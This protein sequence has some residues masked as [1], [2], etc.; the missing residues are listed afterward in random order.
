LSLN[1]NATLP[2]FSSDTPLGPLQPL[3]LASLSSPVPQPIAQVINF[4]YSTVFALLSGQ[5]SSLFFSPNV[6]SSGICLH[7][8]NG[9]NEG[10]VSTVGIINGSDYTLLSSIKLDPMDPTGSNIT[11]LS[12]DEVNE[13]FGLSPDIPFIDILSWTFYVL[14]CVTLYDF[15]Q[16]Y[17]FS[18]GPEPVPSTPS[19]LA[20]EPNIFHNATAFENYNSFLFD[21]ICPL[22]DIENN[23]II[24][25]LPLSD[26][27]R[28]QA[29]GSSLNETYT[30]SQRQLKTWLSLSISVL[31][32]DTAL[33]LGAYG[34]FIFATGYFQERRDKAKAGEMGHC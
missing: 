5:S 7:Y 4:Y 12:S 11:G 33:I 24:N 23:S 34:L 18:S 10:Q 19:K 16:L 17:E 3:N 2:V 30:C 29:T 27:N 13:I 15:G 6:S 20:I 9:V 1:Y 21:V 26:K 28:F 31:S 25:P 14:Q 22:L 8:P 32:A